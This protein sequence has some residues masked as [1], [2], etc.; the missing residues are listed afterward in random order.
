MNCLNLRITNLISPKTVI[1]DT[2]N[3]SIR[4]LGFFTKTLQIYNFKLVYN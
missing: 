1:K 2:N 4:K 3:L